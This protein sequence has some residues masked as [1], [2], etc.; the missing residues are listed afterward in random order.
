MDQLDKR[1]IRG[2]VFIDFEDLEHQ[3]LIEVIKWSHKFISS[4]K[5]QILF[6]LY[7]GFHITWSF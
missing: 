6:S 7:A 3:S 5:C 2:L 4:I 1:F